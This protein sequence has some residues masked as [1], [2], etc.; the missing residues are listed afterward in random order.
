MIM[1]S[2]DIYNNILS[3]DNIKVSERENYAASEGETHTPLLWE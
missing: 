3:C 2:A 1:W